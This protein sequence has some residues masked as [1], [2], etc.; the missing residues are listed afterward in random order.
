MRDFS[1]GHLW[2][3]KIQRKIHVP[4]AQNVTRTCDAYAV[5][6][7]VT[8]CDVLSI[9]PWLSTLTRIAI[10]SLV[11]AVPPVTD[12]I[13]RSRPH[14]RSIPELRHVRVAVVAQ[15]VTAR[16]LVVSVPQDRLLDKVPVQQVLAR[17]NPA[18]VNRR[19]WRALRP[20]KSTKSSV[21]QNAVTN[22]TSSPGNNKAGRLDTQSLPKTHC[23]QWTCKATPWA[24]LTTCRCP[25]GSDH[26]HAAPAPQNTHTRVMHMRGL[27][28][29][30][31]YFVCFI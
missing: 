1:Q 28:S 14:E 30:Q 16:F 26:A 7:A 6:D 20:M 4:R 5:C 12:L 21:E 15:W 25:D 13:Q 9:R 3:R 27:L 22:K 17:R 18:L 24:R 23:N 19:V 29:R 10:R 11:P 8:A 31:S 2:H